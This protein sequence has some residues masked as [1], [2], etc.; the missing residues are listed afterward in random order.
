MQF[1][2]AKHRLEEEFGA[3][4]EFSPTSYSVARRTDEASAA[5]LRPM[6]GVR[7]LQRTDGSLLALFESK[8]WLDR[9]LA[10]QSELVLDP[11]LGNELAG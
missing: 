4:V 2:V 9:V 10:E 11:L 8:F 6:R 5:T 1:D 7:V 3:P